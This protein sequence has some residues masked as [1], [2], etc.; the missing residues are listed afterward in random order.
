MV[1]T[2]LMMQHHIIP[3]QANFVSLHP[4]IKTSPLDRITVPKATQPWTAK[5]HVA[6]V[7]NYG[8]AGSNAALLLR[9]YSSPQPSSNVAA[10]SAVED[11]APP[12]AF[13]PILLSAK[14]PNHL[15]AY[16]DKLKVH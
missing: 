10:T 2:L 11:R 6:L 16:I 13:Y 9:S 7:N 15:R 12:S 1:K 4:R 14:T 8:A 5:R 3:K